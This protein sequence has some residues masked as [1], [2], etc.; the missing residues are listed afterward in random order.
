MSYLKKLKNILPQSKICS[1]YQTLVENHIR[2]AHVIWGNLP[3]TKLHTLQRFRDRALSI[4]K[5]AKIKDKWQ[6]N[7]LIVENLI[8]LDQAVL[9][10]KINNILFPE[11]LWSKFRQRYDSSNYNTRN[12]RNLE[13]PKTNLE[14][15]K[16]GFHRTGLKVWNSIPN[17][18]RELPLLYQFTK[19][20]KTKFLYSL[21]APFFTSFH[22]T[23]FPGRTASTIN[24]DIFLIFLLLS[25]Y[26]YID[27][28][29][30]N[31]DEGNSCIKNCK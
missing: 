29:Y 28:L 6:G 31:L 9:M 22:K 8:K 3:K 11:S 14:K 2:Y 19:S 24:I 7:W 5:N 10:F 21:T 30:C 23:R 12:C 13:I 15:T 17:Q 26:C 16:K 18:V 25:I 4:I 20:L 27:F 1:V